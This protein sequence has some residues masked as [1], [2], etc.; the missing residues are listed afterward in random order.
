MTLIVL[1]LNDVQVNKVGGG[2]VDLTP[3]V[4]NLIHAT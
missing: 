4:S 2:V 1:I 3:G